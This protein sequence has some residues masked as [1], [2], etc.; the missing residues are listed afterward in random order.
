ML[1][2]K[3]ESPD[4]EHEE[5]Q[6]ENGQ[7]LYQRLED[8]QAYTRTSM[9]D[10][11]DEFHDRLHKKRKNE[12]PVTKPEDGKTLIDTVLEEMGLFHIEGDHRYAYHKPGETFLI[13]KS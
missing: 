10:L 4:V 3:L 7:I 6:P 13:Y 8:I 11:L 2:A 1:T 5:T 9:V 12:L